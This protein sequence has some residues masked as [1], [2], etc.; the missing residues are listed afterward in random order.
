V[1]VE[2]WPGR[3]RAGAESAFRVGRRA[4]VEI[5]NRWRRR[6]EA[7]GD[8]VTLVKSNRVR[9][10]LPASSS[11]GPAPLAQVADDLRTTAALLQSLASRRRRCGARQAWCPAPGHRHRDAVCLFNRRAALKVRAGECPIQARRSSE[12]RATSTWDLRLKL[13]AAAVTIITLRRVPRQRAGGTFVTSDPMRWTLAPS[14]MQ[15]PFPPR[16][17]RPRQGPR[18]LAQ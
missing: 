4:G 12:Q 16:R 8:V 1:L 6:A 17:R 9:P 2:S 10:S 7:V 3:L 14:T 15:A 11:S 5:G 13:G 18:R